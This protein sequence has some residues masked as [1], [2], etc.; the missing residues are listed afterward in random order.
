MTSSNCMGASGIGGDRHAELE[1]RMTEGPCWLRPTSSN[2][3]RFALSSH[4][5]TSLVPLSAVYSSQSTT[6]ARIPQLP[7]K[8]PL[9]VKCNCVVRDADLRAFE[10]LRSGTPR[11]FEHQFSEM[12][13]PRTTRGRTQCVARGLPSTGE[14]EGGRSG[15]DEPDLAGFDRSEDISSSS[16][17]AA[18]T[19]VQECIK[20]MS[21]RESIERRR[22]GG[23][24]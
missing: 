5:R 15:T 6:L 21:C 3:W 18:S 19:N 20:C 8:L 1:F 13:R 23:G 9:R 24:Q 22:G 2:I 17:Q 12:G 11:C 7:G 14:A 4:Q 10:R 16:V